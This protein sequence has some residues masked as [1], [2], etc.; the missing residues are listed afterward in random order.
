MKRIILLA[1]LTGAPLHAQGTRVLLWASTAADL[2]STLN[3]PAGYREG[4]PILGQNRGRQAATM[5]SLTALTDWS[6]ARTKHGTRA[7]LIVTA[8]HVFCVGWNF[9][10]KGITK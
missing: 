7:R 9:K 5:L 1:F 10:A 3:R 2:G 8:V 6:S 4:N